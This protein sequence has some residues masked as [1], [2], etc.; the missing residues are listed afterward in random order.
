MMTGS[1]VSTTNRPHVVIV[2]GGFA[3]LQAAKSLRRADVDV[4]LLDRRNFH[5]FQPLL[6]QV[7]T[8]ELSPAN[9]ATPLRAILRKQ[10]NARVLLG[11]VKSIDVPGRQLA[12]TDQVIGFDYLI[13]A[14]GA[15]HHYFGNDHWK[16]HAPGLK[17]VENATRIRR[18]VLGAFEAAE[19]CDDEQ[20]RR[21]LLTFVVIGGGPTGCE[22]AGT[23]AEIA[24]HTLKHDFRRIDTSKARIVLIEAS[25]APLE[26]Y[27]A[28]LPQRAAADLD[29]LGVEIIANVMATDIQASHVTIQHRS[30]GVTETIATRTVVW[31]AGVKAN[32]LGAMM[33][34]STEIEPARG[35]R[36]PVGDDLSIAGHP[37]VLVCGD[38]AYRVD[39]D[40]GELPGLA[41]VATQM[42]HHAAQCI[43]ADRKGLARPAFSYRDKGSLAVIGRY[44]AVG[45]IGNWKVKGFIAWFIWISVHLMYITMFRNRLLVLAQW[46]WTFFSHDRSAR[47]IADGPNSDIPTMEEAS[48]WDAE[49]V[50]E[51]ATTSLES[52]AK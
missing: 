45:V 27:P 2:G 21:E 1:S 25:D 23:M 3:G 46:G 24:R 40:H 38:L 41:P 31:A 47:L 37:N 8:G 39:P 13:L 12:L 50:V 6:Y 16:H 52:F 28:P 49:P 36:V 42:G 29:R 26:V 9:I 5:L 32:P 44:S 15:S 34:V 11:E 10:R 51:S 4:T 20:Q 14:A 35:G 22:M 17:T 33:C 7:A 19:R 30:T 43:Q 18:D 48:G